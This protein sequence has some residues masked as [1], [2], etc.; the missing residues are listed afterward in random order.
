MQ[1]LTDIS[2]LQAWRQDAKGTVGFVP[3]MGALHRGHLTLV[4]AAL[5]NNDQVVVS[6]FVNPTQFDQASD[7]AH[8]PNTLAQDLQQLA[9]VGVTA[10]LLPNQETMYP[11]DYRY[12]VAEN[13]LSRLYCGA[14]RAGHFDG[15]LSVVMKLFNLVQPTRAYF[16]EKDFQQLTLI[17]GMVQAFFLPIEIVPCPVVRESDGLAMSSRNL[18]LSPIERKIAPQLY[19]TLTADTSLA[20]KR[21]RLADLGFD[22]DYLEV[23]QDRLLVAAKLGEIRLI[24]NVPFLAGAGA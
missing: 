13:E 12:Q 10:V 24:D 16:G 2:A 6:I 1:R 21:Q 4:E 14:H 18:R 7:L 15:V 22:L 11:D 8:Y 20:D 3:T 17:Q 9:D 19:A 23:Y 5:A